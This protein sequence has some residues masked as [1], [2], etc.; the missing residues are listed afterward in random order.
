MKN[1][2]ICRV[3]WLLH[4]LSTDFKGRY[5]LYYDYSLHRYLFYRMSGRKL[6][7]LFSVVRTSKRCFRVMYFNTAA[8]VQEYFSCRTSSQ[9]AEF[10]L[11][12]AE[13]YK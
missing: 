10:M 5:I 11:D 1:K 3:H 12:I 13:Y 7:D 8:G 6:H 2:K 9:C 4:N